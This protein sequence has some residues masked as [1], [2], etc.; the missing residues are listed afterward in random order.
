MRIIFVRHGEPDYE[1]D[2]LTE[3]GVIQAGQAAIRLKEEGIEEIYASPLGRAHQT[4]EAASA[5]LGLPIHTLDYMRELHWGSIDGNPL[6]HN[7]HP[8]DMADELARQGWDL[9][10]PGWRGHEFYSNNIVTAE[11]DEVAAQ[12]DKWLLSLGYERQGAYYRN[13]REDN[14]QH[15]VALFSHGGS[16]AAA[17]GHILNLTFPYSCALFH[18]E[19]T[20]ITIIRFNRNPGVISLPCLELANDGRHIRESYSFYHRLADM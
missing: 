12:T 14:S 4:A 8:W 11:V 3:T 17:M 15:T 20:G 18:I 13:I 6:Y 19:F 1:H 7:G 16:S 10:D 5:V 9:T 2:C